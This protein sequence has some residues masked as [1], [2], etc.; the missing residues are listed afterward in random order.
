[1]SESDEVL[2]EKSYY[3]AEYL[4]GAYRAESTNEWTAASEITSKNSTIL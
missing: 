2:H 4:V 3:N 1:M